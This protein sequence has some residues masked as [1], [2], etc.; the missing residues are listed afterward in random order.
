MTC[1]DHINSEIIEKSKP[2]ASTNVSDPYGRLYDTVYIQCLFSGS[3][4][5]QG[6]RWLIW[7]HH[8]CGKNDLFTNLACTSVG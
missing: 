6:V 2:R 4:Q 1:Q 5:I 8:L 7:L 3:A